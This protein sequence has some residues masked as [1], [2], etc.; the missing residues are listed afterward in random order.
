MVEILAETELVIK[1]IDVAGYE[2]V[3]SIYHKASNLKAFIAI[4]N[5]KLGPALGGIRIYDY[6]SEEEAL[7][8]VLRLSK[9]MTY[10]AALAGVGF[11]GGK[12]VI[13]TSPEG[14][15]KSLLKAFAKAVD[16]M[17]GEYI[18]AIDVGCSMDDIETIYSVT[19]F[20]AGKPFVKDIGSGDPSRFTS[21]GI[22][23]GILATVHQLDGKADLNGIKILIQGLGHVGSELLS[24]LFW[25]GA[26]LY[27]Y[28]ICPEKIKQAQQSYG[29][30]IISEKE[31]YNFPC[32]IFAPCAMGGIINQQTIPQLRCRAICGGANN[33]LLKEKTD[34]EALKERN[35]L[36]APDFVVNAGGLLNVALELSAEGYKPVI[37]YDQTKNIYNSLKAI[38]EIAEKNDIS[39]YNAAISLADHRICYGIGKRKESP[40][41]Y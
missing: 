3:V 26:D 10:K 38:Y 20:V 41:F 19:P 16:T 4:H 9:G 2:K 12:S 32:D 21:W 24:F 17:Q 13:M 29:V 11:G 33:Q 23:Q 30:K 40:K 1:K 5:T 36:Y 31:I 39:T 6:S 18:C 35:I 27:A 14:K 37:A 15:T 22:F 28:D 25:A 8:D 34:S 7:R